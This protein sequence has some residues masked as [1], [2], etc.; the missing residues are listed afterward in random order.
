MQ[1]ET[2]P[3]PVP[4]LPMELISGGRGISTSETSLTKERVAFNRPEPIMIFETGSASLILLQPLTGLTSD[5]LRIMQQHQCCK[6]TLHCIAYVSNPG[7]SCM[8][9][10]FMIYHMIDPKMLQVTFGAKV[11]GEAI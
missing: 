1:P 7:I 3:A 11:V 6:D 9:Y 5:E 8:T 4:H 10:V 2:S